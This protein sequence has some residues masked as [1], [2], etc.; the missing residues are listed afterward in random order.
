MRT[1][2]AAGRYLALGLTTL[3]ALAACGSARG[4]RGGAGSAAP[5]GEP[6]PAFVGIVGHWTPVVEGGPAFKVDGERWSG[7]TERSHLE[8]VARPLFPTP[9]DGFVANGTA[10]GA[11]PLAVF[12]DVPN[13]SGGTL[14]VQFKLLGGRSD[15]TAGI[16]LGL[17]PTGEYLF[18]RYNTKDGNVAVWQYAGGERRVIAHGTVKAQLPLDTWHELAVTVSGA[19][20]TGVVDGDSLKVEHTLATPVTGR[21]GLW[22]KRDAVTVFRDF[23]VSP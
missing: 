1:R 15:Q 22:T 10:P 5:A 13:F 3:T 9:D 11:F 21:V 12:R 16:V 19:T 20:V 4:A 18:V 8:A 7:M 2:L 23:R 14:R 6:R 17:Q